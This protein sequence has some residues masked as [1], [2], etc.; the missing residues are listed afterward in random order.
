MMVLVTATSL[1]SVTTPR[2]P[3]PAPASLDMTEMEL[4]AQV[5]IMSLF[6]HL[7]TTPS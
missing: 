5:R 1:P 3:S 7:L 4:P 2:D 6:Y